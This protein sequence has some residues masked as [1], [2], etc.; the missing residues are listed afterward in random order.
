MKGS[1]ILEKINDPALQFEWHEYLVKLQSALDDLIAVRRKPEDDP[2]RL[3]YLE[4]VMQFADARDDERTFF[5]DT[6]VEERIKEI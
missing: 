6:F 4:A 2:A 3:K 1:L 5:W